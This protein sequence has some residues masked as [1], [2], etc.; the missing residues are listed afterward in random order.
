MAKAEEQAAAAKAASEATAAAAAAE[1]ARKE[2]ETAQ[3]KA[4]AEAAHAA[5]QK[6]KSERA[7]ASKREALAKK[8]SEAE[9]AAAAEAKKKAEHAAAQEAK[10]K[11]ERAA[12]NKEAEAERAAA[13]EAKKKAEQAAAQEAKAKAERAAASKEAAL[14]KKRRREEQ[15]EANAAS[16]RRREEKQVSTTVLTQEDIQPA[17]SGGPLPKWSIGSK[18]LVMRTGGGTTPCTVIEYDAKHEWPYRVGLDGT[19]KTKMATEAMLSPAPAAPPVT[20]TQE[21]NY[22][23]AEGDNEAKRQKKRRGQMV[24]YATKVE[25]KLTEIHKDFLQSKARSGEKLKFYQLLER[26]QPQIEPRLHDALQC[27]RKWRNI[28]AHEDGEKEVLPIDEEMQRMMARI[29]RAGLLITPSNSQEAPP[30]AAAAASTSTSRPPHRQQ[31]APA[32]RA[33]Q[34]RRWVGV[35]LAGSREVLVAP[36]RALEKSSSRPSCDDLAS[37]GKVR[38][39]EATN[40]P[41]RDGTHGRLRRVAWPRPRLYPV[42]LASHFRHH[43]RGFSFRHLTRAG[44]ARRRPPRP[45]ASNRV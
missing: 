7:A 10:A 20:L 3:A 43:R 5:A 27:I 18:L 31:S 26:L 21:V 16:K 2:E 42:A 34:R 23:D 9:R 6:A 8:Q 30:A 17:A 14:E 1:M 13:Q 41:L 4:E 37:A 25:R 38:R 39:Y 35:Q 29:R 28:A 45:R 19:D 24:D 32:I 11:A 22:G 15:E 12:A 44:A 33:S 40:L 36:C